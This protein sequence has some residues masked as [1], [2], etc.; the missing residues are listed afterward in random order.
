MSYTINL[1][2]KDNNGTI[3][4]S[5]ITSYVT[6][7]FSFVEKLDDSLDTGQLTIRG[8]TTSTPYT[9]FDTIQ[10]KIGTTEMFS[11]RIAS[12]D[13][14]LIS[15]NPLK[16]EHKLMLIEHTKIMELFIVG[17]KTFTQ[18]TDGT[19]KYYLYDT[20]D[21][22]FDTTPFELY[23]EYA[24]NRI[25][26]LPSSGDLY[27]ILT[28]L[29]SPEYTFKDLTLRECVKQVGDYIDAIPRLFLNSS[30]DLEL[31]FDFVNDLK[32]LITSNE[33]YVSL[34]VS[35]EPTF[36]ATQ[37]E[38]DS[39]NLVSDET[40]GES[41]EVYPA[42]N[43]YTTLRRP[44][45]FLQENFE[46]SVAPTPKPIST[47]NAIVVFAGIQVQHVSSSDF[48][49]SGSR[50]WEITKGLVEEKTY[51]QLEFN[52]TGMTTAVDYADFKDNCLY[53]KYKEKNVY[54]G[55][56]Y[57][58]YGISDVYT[59]WFERG[60]KQILKDEGVIDGTT[61]QYSDIYDIT[62]SFIAGLPQDLESKVYRIKYVPIPNSMRLN[63]ERED[64][65]DVMRFSQLISN[66]QDRILNLENFSNNLQGK[67]NRIGNSEL[68]LANKFPLNKV[69][70]SNNIGDYTEELYIVTKKES[71]FFPDFVEYGYGLSRNF[72]KI[73]SFI[74]VNSEI[75]QWEIGEKNTL[76]RVP[77][78]KEYVEIDVIDSGN[79]SNTAEVITDEGIE[80]YLDTFNPSSS[81]NPVSVGAI[82]TSGTSNNSIV[83]IS[84][85]GGGNSLIF[86]FKLDDNV[87]AGF[88][89]VDEDSQMVKQ[90][91]P[92]TASDGSFDNYTL[93]IMES[94]ADIPTFQFSVL[95]ASN[96]VPKIITLSTETSWTERLGTIYFQGRFKAYKDSREIFG[97]TYQLAQIPKRANDIILGRHLS[98]RN[99]LVSLDAPSSLKLY[100]STTEQFKRTDNFIVPSTYTDYGSFTPSISNNFYKI[101]ISEV[102]SSWTSWCLTDEND[103]ILIGANQE[104]TKLDTIT[105]DFKN[106]RSGINYKY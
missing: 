4:T 65:N 76:E 11:L 19:T 84:S 83:S 94:M 92:Y 101:I 78:Y 74:G 23:D 64:A 73:S 29:P 24:S 105:F 18:P 6:T 2:S 59:L 15:K 103:R 36:Y 45:D 86:N 48:I 12:D 58:V 71:I 70:S 8:V 55:E 39:L 25:I 102:L 97:N 9:L 72:N 54:I 37:I 49:Y 80:C 14:S 96:Y 93:Y 67:I 51:Q 57:G 33:D 85:N 26:V 79:G 7:G 43:Y 46:G 91:S 38:S 100:Y 17:G 63:M 104:G 90:Y 1:I 10:C 44:E 87:S 34:Q 3:T 95:D 62:F 66:Q 5:N 68:E 28:T 31:S 75:R 13:V 56:T 22:L 99:R 60:V 32:E 30:G 106:K 16:Y 52:T 69:S 89:K 50:D 77:V 81:L 88:Y 42:S 53:Y 61:Y 82:D 40:I 27:D 20:L 21:I 35:Q 47:L 98:L 41:I